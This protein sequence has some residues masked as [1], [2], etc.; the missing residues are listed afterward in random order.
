M[1]ATWRR[2]LVIL[3]IVALAVGA[4]TFRKLCLSRELQGGSV[5]LYKVPGNPDAQTLEEVCR[6]M[7][8]RAAT[9]GIDGVRVLPLQRTCEVRVELPYLATAE[10]DRLKR[11][12]TIRTVEEIMDG[13]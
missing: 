12:L 1:R 2:I 8:S 7:E 3:G 6:I 11:V 10:R 4:L 9:L 13:R 5:L